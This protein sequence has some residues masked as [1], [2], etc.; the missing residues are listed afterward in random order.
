MDNTKNPFQ[1]NN[2]PNKTYEI[3]VLVSW[4]DIS[5]AEEAVLKKEGQ[6]LEIKGFRKGMAPNNLVRETLGDQKLLQIILGEILPELYQKAVAQFNLKPIV[7][8]K[9]ELVS[10]KENEDWQIKLTTCEEPEI[11]LSDYREQIKKALPV[12][13]EIWT[14]GE[15][16]DDKEKEDKNKRAGLILDWLVQNI[17][18]GMSR[19]LIEDEVSRKLSQL[20]EEIQKLGLTLENYLSSTGKTVETVKDEYAKSAERSLASEFIL[21]KIADMEK[22][23][24]SD[25]DLNKMLSEA[26]SEAE[27]KTMENQKYYI[28]ILLRRQ[29]TLDFLSDL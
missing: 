12:K 26:K 11:N 29:K 20:L 15:K 21:G 17:K 27:R 25:E 14:P 7:N 13:A 2:L 16:K 10:A 23:S 6:S 9:I 3:Q 18:V 19:L 22:I 5:E 28:A 8:P 1:I 4:N 24:V